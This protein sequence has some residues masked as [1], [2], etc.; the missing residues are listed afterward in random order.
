MLP[1]CNN[2]KRF[3]FKS[4]VF[5]SFL[6]NLFFLIRWRVK[7]LYISEV[8]GEKFFCINVFQATVSRF[9]KD[10]FFFFSRK[11]IRSKDNRKVK[12]YLEYGYV[13]NYLKSK[14]LL[15]KCSCITSFEHQY[16]ICKSIDSLKQICRSAKNS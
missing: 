9:Q 3:I 6:L 10:F 13:R 2:M 4:F 7:I 16:I 12:T 8:L 1:Y 14:I 5:S 11:W 15:W